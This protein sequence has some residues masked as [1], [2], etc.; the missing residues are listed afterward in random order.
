MKTSGMNR[1]ERQRKLKQAYQLF[2][3]S[4]FSVLF[5]ATLLSFACSSTT[6]TET[7]NDARKIPQ[8]I[9]SLTPSTTEILAG[10]GAFPRVVAVSDYCKYPPE[11]EALPRVGG[12]QNTNI[13]RIV[14]LKPDLVV[15]T[16]AQ[17]PFVKDRFE[18]LGIRTTA[19]KSRTLDDA[20]TAITEIG[21]ATGN[22]EQADKLFNETRSQLDELRA[23]TRNLPRPRVLCVVDRAPGTLRDVYAATKESFIAQLI[24][25]A[26]GEVIAP[27]STS[28]YGQ[29]SK[30]AILSFDPEIIIDMVQGAEAAGMLAEDS[31]AVWRELAEVRAVKTNRVY[32]IGDVSV[33]HPSQFVGTTARR[34][35]QLIH[36]E[37]FAR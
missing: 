16:D 35:A 12:W 14:A 4:I 27:S 33:L 28:G 20:L 8:R 13:E 18:S 9:V 7:G 24:E 5:A 17:T 2:A 26:G 32:P 6:K 1:V 34:F 36:P 30:E 25:I 23:R 37:V 19:V 15:F 21:R 22:T 31:E 10:I 11:V 29:I 3:S